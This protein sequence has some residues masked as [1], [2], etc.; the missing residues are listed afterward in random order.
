MQLSINARSLSIFTGADKRGRMP[1]SGILCHLDTPSDSPPGGANGKRIIVT[2]SAG[3]AA[4]GCLLGMGV[5]STPSFDGHSQKTKIGVIESASIT[6][7]ISILI[8]GFVYASDFPEVARTIK[9]MKDALGFSFEAQRLTVLDPRAAVLTITE[10]TFTGAAI[11]FKGSAAFQ[12]TSLA[13][14]ASAEAEARGPDT[15]KIIKMSSSPFV[16]Q[17]CFPAPAPKKQFPYSFTSPAALAKCLASIGFDMPASVTALAAAGQPLGKS[18]CKIDVHELDEIL[19]RYEIS[20]Q[21]R[22]QLKS[23][24]VRQGVL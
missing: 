19:S 14:S 5:N 11:L 9:A 16:Q 3:R 7:G 13:A 6:A 20:T 24:M 2:S 12:T 10:L 22:M 23:E 18:G 17:N 8:S 21:K 15:R 1:F 4:L